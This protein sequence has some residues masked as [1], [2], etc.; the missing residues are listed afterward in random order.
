MVETRPL[1]VFICYSHRDDPYRR[2]LET[3][4]AGLQGLLEVWS[5]RHIEA[6]LEWDKTI[7]ERLETADIF[8]LLI[9][10]DF[11]AS[12][13]CRE[14]ELK[15]AME[16]HEAG[17][18]R[19]IPVFVRPCYWQG[20]VFGKIQ[21]VP[22]SNKP[23][24]R[25]ED[26][27][28]A[29]TI[30]VAEIHKAAASLHKAA[31]SLRP[32]EPLA[33]PKPAPADQ[34]LAEPEP[35][36]QSTGARGQAPP[37]GARKEDQQPDDF[38]AFCDARLTPEMVVLPAGEVLMGSPDDDRKAYAD[39]RPQHSVRIGYRLAVGRSPVTFAEWDA[40]L[41]EGGVRYRPDDEG[42]GRG[43][44]P[45]IN[46]N[47]EDA[48]QYLAWLRRKTGHAYRLLSEAEWEYAARSGMP[49]RYWWGDD[50]TPQNANY[51][52]S[53]INKTTK[54]GMYPESPFNLYDILGNVWEWTEDCWNPSY[55][56]APEDGSA[57]KSGDCRAR[58]VRGGSW[59]CSAR[60]VRA[61]TRKWIPLDSRDF[62]IG[63]RVARRL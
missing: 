49:M 34:R 55:E 26:R 1:R 56:G 5:D 13:F 2:D 45:V 54:A 21:G 46:V 27:D 3:H 33:G 24:S 6:G 35:T 53:N 57:W 14:R 62:S 52:D 58:V 10:P 38:T 36:V 48:Q 8:L 15:R 4:L 51:A 59:I 7:G 17:K 31:A 23:I 41:A 32:H 40:C 28:E 39:E 12:E 11:L 29:F 61:A 44:R 25:W 37:S 30:V 22:D 18:A 43:R 19:V 47:W 50:I 63:F 42:W 60:D 16:R 20:M 9:S